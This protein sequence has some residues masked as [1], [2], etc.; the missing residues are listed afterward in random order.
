MII[1]Q[2]SASDLVAYRE[3]HRFGMTESPDGFVDVAATDAARPDSDVVAM[4]ARGDGWGAF[5][6]D[7][8]IG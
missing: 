5:D 3:L 7:R 2:L 4:L 8:L 1:R 6:G